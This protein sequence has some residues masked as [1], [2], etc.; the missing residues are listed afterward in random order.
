M[1]L[2]T[3]VVLFLVSRRAEITPFPVITPPVKGFRSVVVYTV[4]S[5]QSILVKR[6]DG[7]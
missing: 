4:A 6:I 2:N 7:I 5:A 1:I 3:T